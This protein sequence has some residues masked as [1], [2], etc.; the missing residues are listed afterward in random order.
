MGKCRFVGLRISRMCMGILRLFLCKFSPRWGALPSHSL[1][2]ARAEGSR[3]NVASW[4]R[5]S[6]ESTWTFTGFFSVSSPSAGVLYRPIHWSLPC[7][8]CSLGVTGLSVEK[9]LCKRRT[10]YFAKPLARRGRRPPR[11]PTNPANLRGHS[12]AFPL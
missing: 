1:A 4:A 8:I 5:E 6:R 9:N 7:Q 3:A 10:M 11:R 12:L 2:S